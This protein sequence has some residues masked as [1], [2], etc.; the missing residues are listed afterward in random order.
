MGTNG[1]RKVLNIILGKRGIDWKIVVKMA[2]KA[3]DWLCLTSVGYCA[4]SQT[5]SCQSEN[6]ENDNYQK[7][8]FA[9]A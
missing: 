7:M 9:R 4:P 8:T 2:V 3:K 5:N 6:S 1:S